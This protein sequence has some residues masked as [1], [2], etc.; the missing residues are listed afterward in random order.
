MKLWSSS[1]IVVCRLRQT[2]L[3]LSAVSAV[4]LGVVVMRRFAV[5]NIGSVI[6]AARVAARSGRVW[7][8]TTGA[9]PSLPDRSLLCSGDDEGA[10]G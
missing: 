9:A 10:A 6:A 5:H 2:A 8:D 1:P 3:F 7:K 4:G